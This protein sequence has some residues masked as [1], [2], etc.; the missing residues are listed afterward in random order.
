MEHFVS[1]YTHLALLMAALAIFGTILPR[2]W[3]RITDNTRLPLPPGLKGIPAVGWNLRELLA[4]TPWLGFT[5][6]QNEYGP[7]VH[8]TAPFRQHI[9][10][11]NTLEA[12]SNILDRQSA[13]TSYR[14]RS[15]LLEILTNGLMIPFL[16]RENQTYRRV[17][18]ALQA[19]LKQY[20]YE[21]QQYREAVHLVRNILTEVQE[22]SPVRKWHDKIKDQCVR[23]SV[24]MIYGS[25]I[26]SGPTRSHKVDW[27]V[28]VLKEFTETMTK[29]A[30]PGLIDVVP[31]LPS[32]IFPWEEEARQKFVEYDATFVN[33]LNESW[34]KRP[35]CGSAI[36]GGSRLVPPCHDP[37]PE[38]QQRLHCEIDAALGYDKLP[39]V[40]ELEQIPYLQATVREALRWRPVAPLGLP[41][42]ASSD[43]TYGGYQI[44]KG[45]ILIANIW[46]INWSTELFGDDAPAFRPERHLTSGVKPVLS[47][48]PDTKEEG[49]VSFGLGRRACAGRLFAKKMLLINIGL[50]MWA[51]KVEAAEPGEVG[52]KLDVDGCLDKG[53]VVRPVPFSCKIIERCAGALKILEQTLAEQTLAEQTLAEQTL[54]EQTLAEQALAEL[55]HEEH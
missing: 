12:A 31:W 51:A 34:E 25:S 21:S 5:A 54:A 36:T 33:L 20:P 26:S 22:H 16:N 17:A 46:A 30:T 11:L 3:L 27:M 35:R 7:I 19:C 43:F 8:L 41:H 28:K 49:H 13:V 44:P 9:V 52:F 32:W 4:K 29:L 50:L 23:F 40:E 2:C 10:I 45:T 53:V 38:V 48:P 42:V 14:P 15:I 47:A 37:Y 24:E 1:E 39:S 55:Q 6:L 18:K